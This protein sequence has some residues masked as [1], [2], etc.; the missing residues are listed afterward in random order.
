MRDSPLRVLLSFTRLLVYSFT[1][2]R[3]IRR[4]DCLSRLLV[5]VCLLVYLFTSSSSQNRRFSSSRAA[6]SSPF[7][8]CKA[9]ARSSK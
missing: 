3:V 4:F 8:R 2:K 5:Y 9:R 1:N 7:V 6:C